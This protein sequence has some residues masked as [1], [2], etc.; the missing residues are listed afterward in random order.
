[1]FEHQKRSYRRHI[2]KE[3]LKAF[4]ITVQETDL[5]ILADRPLEREAI[6]SVLQYRGYIEAYIRQHPAFGTAYSPWTPP[7]PAPL[8]VT[9]MVEA[10]ACAGVGPMAAV[11]GAIAEKVAQDLLAFSKEVVVENGGD[12]CLQLNAPATV[13]IYAGKSPLSMKI[14]IVLQPCGQPQAVCTSSGTI[15]HSHSFG[16][17]D[18]VCVLAQS[19]ALADAVATAVANRVKGPADVRSAVDFGK[20]IPGLTG[21]VIVC[22]EKLGVW[23]N[24]EVVPIQ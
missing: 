15:G 4:Q 11:A 12:I 7:G 18:A 9:D 13:G 17:A 21:I 10:A 20:S 16:Q 3:N 6:E 24:L 5:H 8:I 2:R 23:G 22:G 19:C 1:M 14:G